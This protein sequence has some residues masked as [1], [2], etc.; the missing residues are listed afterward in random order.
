MKSM[1][2]IAVLVPALIVAATAVPASA[3]NLVVNSGFETG[4][5]SGWTQGGNLGSTYVSN[6]PNVPHS[7]S[8]AAQLGP[9]TTAGTL[10]QVLTTVAGQAYDLS[11]WL[12]NSTLQTPDTF[13]VSWNGRTISGPS[14]V[15][16]A[17]WLQE[18]FNVI[19][20]GSDT[21][22]FTF[23][24]DPNYIGLDDVSVAASAPS[25]VPEPGTW[26]ML[27]AGVGFIGFALRRW[28]RKS[29]DAFTAKVREAYN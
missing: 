21:L 7:G 17:T 4:S 5:F 14:A 15:T 8:Y 11:F 24:D 6:A 1:K 3:A 27:L 19:G 28:H 16:N 9:V 20:T 23:R 10:S 12:Q 22:T 26:A 29:E 25:A 13:A 2:T 18:A